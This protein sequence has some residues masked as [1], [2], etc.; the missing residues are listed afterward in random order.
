[1]VKCLECQ[2]EKKSLPGHIWGKHGMKVVDYRA[3]Y[4][5]D[6]D[7]GWTAA[8]IDHSIPKNT[9]E[10]RALN[11]VLKSASSPS[12]VMFSSLS[13]AEQKQYD[14]QFNLLFEQ[15]SRDAVLIPMIR[16]IVMNQLFIARYQLQLEKMSNKFV[17]GMDA[18]TAMELHKLVQNM[19]ETNLKN[20]DSLNLTKAK[21][22]SLNKT[23]ESTPSKVVSAFAHAVK[24]MTPEEREKNKRDMNEA[25]DR[26]RHNLDDL[27]TLVNDSEGEV[28]EEIEAVATE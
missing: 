6:V 8:N 24:L 14:E 10:T 4:G 1:M 16:D 11:K 23:P 3:K 13:L 12:A 28:T 18:K 26:L 19:Q 15:A 2:A 9:K 5:K 21:K 17:N 25:M 7:L 27:L 20:L 22:D